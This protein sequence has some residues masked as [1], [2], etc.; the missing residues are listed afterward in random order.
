MNEQL[1]W[2]AGKELPPARRLLKSPFD[3]EARYSRK[4]QTE[5]VGY[6]VHLTE[7]CDDQS[8]NVITQVMTTRASTND[9]VVLP[10]IHEALAQKDLLPDEHFVD[11]G[12]ISAVDLANAQ[13]NYAINLMGFVREE[14]SWQKATGYDVS[15]FAIDWDKQQVTLSTGADLDQLDTDSG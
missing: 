11:A 5:W 12:Y 3:L 1:Q 7:T 2:R 6:K 9:I 8:L 4:R 13:T 14:S 15:A 10:D